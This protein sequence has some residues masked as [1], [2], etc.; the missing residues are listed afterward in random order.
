MCRTIVYHPLTHPQKRIWYIEKIFPGTSLHNIGGP[1]RI[2]GEVD[3]DS[4]EQ[5]IQIFIQKNEGLRLRF[6]EINGEAVQYVEQFSPKIIERMDFSQSLYPREGFN[7]WIEQEAARPFELMEN[8]LF[9]FALFSLGPHDNGYFLRFHHIIADGWSINIMTEQVFDIY[10]SL[11]NG[12]KIDKEVQ[13]SYLDYIYQEQDYLKSERFLKDKAFWQ[14]KFQTLPESLSIKYSQNTVGKRIS[15]TLDKEISDAMTALVKKLNCSLNILFVALYLI[16]HHKYSAERDIIIGTP[17]LNRSGKKQKGM[18]GMFTST[19]PFR[20]NF[21][22]GLTVRQMLQKVNEELRECYYHQKYPYNVL[23]QDL[24]L[25]K[26]DYDGLFKVC[27]N[28]YN[29]KLNTDLNGI[30][31]ENVEFYNG[32]QFYSLQLVIKSW[33]EQGLLT[34][35]YDFKLEDYEDN[36]ITRMHRQLLTLVEQVIEDSEKSVDELSLL[37]PAEQRKWLY[38]YNSTGAD[39]PRDKVIYQL[40]EEQ[41]ERAPENIAIRFGNAKMTY[42]ELNKKSNQLARALRRKGIGKEMIVGLMTTHSPETVIGILGILKAGGA[43]LP[44][45]PNYPRERIEFMLRDSETQLLLTNVADCIE[46]DFS[47]EI[48][49]LDD[50]RIYNGDTTNLTVA[51]EPKD[52]VYVIYTSGSTGKPKGVM[53]EHGGLVNYT[54]WARK[55]YVRSEEEAFALYSSLAF[56]LTVTSVF[57]P[58]IGGN[59][60]VI[61]HD[62]GSDFILYSI[63]RDNTVN[64]IKLTPAHLAL[65][66]DLDN[67]NSKVRRFIVGGEDLK[68][69]LAAEIRQSFAGEIEIYNEYGPTETVVGCMIHRYSYEEDS[70]VSV[71]VG[72]P[73][74]NVQIYLLNW[75]MQPVPEGTPGEIY[76]S[77]AGVARGYLNRPDLTEERFL[78]NPFI[79]GT[80]MYKTGDLAK[81]NSSGKIIYL[82]RIDQ[83]VKIRGFRI[84]LG[85]I[86]KCLANYPGIKDV[87]VTDRDDM[88]NGKYLCAYLVAGAEIDPV[89]IRDFLGQRLPDYMVPQYY[90]IMEKLPLTTNGKVDRTRL[91][92]PQRDMN[93]NTEQSRHDCNETESILLQV[94]EEVLHMGG[95]RRLDNFFQIG[96]DS[97]KAIQIATKLNS[98]GKSIKVRDILSHPVFAEMAACIEEKSKNAGTQSFPCEGTV[99]PTPIT[100]WF[101][102]RGFADQNYW[103]QSV[104]LELREKALEPEGIRKALTVLVRHHDS[105]RLNYD[106]SIHKLFYNPNHLKLEIGLNCVDLSSL[107]PEEQLLSLKQVGESVKS[108]M[109]IER[110]LLFRTALFELGGGKR[111]LLLTAHHLVV[112]GVS[113]RILL[114]DLASLMKA[115]VNGRRLELPG[116]TSSYQKWAQKLMENHR[117]DAMKEIDYWSSLVQTGGVLSPELNF[118]DDNLVPASSITGELSEKASEQLLTKANLAYNTQP[119]ELLIMAL[120]MAIRDVSGAEKVMIELEGHGREE[121]FE[122]ID[123]SRT[124]GWYTSMYPICLEL[125]GF[126]LDK[127]VKSLKEQIRKLPN[128]GINFGVLRFLT[129]AL[130]VTDDKWVRLNYL[131]DFDNLF[132]TGCFELS[133]LDT[134][135]D[136]SPCNKTTALLEI[137][138][139]IIAGRLQISMTYDRNRFTEE[140]SRRFLEIFI[141]RIEILLKHCCDKNERDFTPSDFETV[142]VSQDDLDKLFI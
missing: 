127:Q 93:R 40:F 9:Y 35:D 63:L 67:S 141:E 82:G 12:Q 29:T 104:L 19:V 115:V 105:L 94:V 71:P 91:P 87:F 110:D 10:L 108:G 64:I 48:V 18:F 15:F 109:D 57:T 95:I 74:A 136:C 133:R 102:S 113:W 85:E 52:L 97:I 22:N 54:W 89:G 7:T 51:N 62:D 125:P 34:L 6:K 88:N 16:L 13:Y 32:N 81:F 66:K 92:E 128:K 107:S 17:V 20:F 23:F 60:I 41:A 98:L 122:D 99:E 27:I 59:T 49:N 123:L 36:H 83:Q 79:P 24:Q 90:M 68:R 61:Y 3:F 56:D 73:A 42:A 121:L 2:K 96:G 28:Y 103:N 112:D 1:I 8:D 131:G 140:W 37:S 30:P 84:E 11:V 72:I 45:D 101:F 53:I 38:E 14:G 114:E 25:K 129:H 139:L 86:E 124:V 117:N 78:D 58:L 26:R 106:P 137:N 55:V 31:V 5:A 126:P 135:H 132:A 65:L 118:G 47:G 76:I 142:E 21:E 69:N 100:E 138:A 4:L 119:N 80:R 130:E 70:S 75:A 43:Y 116:K 77:G 50:Q 134:G 46:L 111:L 33:S 44:I 120:A 39:Y